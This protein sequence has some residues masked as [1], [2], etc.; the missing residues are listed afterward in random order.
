MKK[1][2]VWLSVTAGLLLAA[3]CASTGMEPAQT[4]EIGQK[5][6]TYSFKRETKE[7]VMIVD[8]ELARMRMEE[9]YI[10][11]HIKI[12]NKRLPRLVITRESLTLIDEGSQKSYPMPESIEVEK[13][14][15]KLAPDHKFKSQTGFLV[16]QM[17][18]S[19]SGYIQAQSNFFPQTQGAARV[20]ERVYIR[21]LGFMEDLIYFPMPEGGVKGKLLRLRLESAELKA[22][23]DF[24]FAVD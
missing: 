22:P 9:N 19:F 23:F 14:Y 20:I 5:Y 4:S 16:D 13:N 10:P 12:A 21:Q 1:I 3:S 2:L 8:V 18:T 11:L 24:V 7:L 15:N 17:T 6:S